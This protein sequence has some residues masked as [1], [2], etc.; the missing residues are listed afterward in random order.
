MKRLILLLLIGLSACEDQ[1]KQTVDG[2]NSFSS[3]ENEDQPIIDRIWLKYGNKEEYILD[4]VYVFSDSDSLVNQTK[5]FTKGR[6]DTLNSHFYDFSFVREND[7]LVKVN[8]NYFSDLY[9]DYKNGIAT[10]HLSIYFTDQLG[11]SIIH[12]TK[13]FD[14]VPMSDVVVSFNLH[15]KEKPILNGFILEQVILK[16]KEYEENTIFRGYTYIDS[17]IS[18]N[19]FD[20]RQYCEK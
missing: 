13:H 18:S 5:I 12:S 17:H 11:D 4:E 16:N 20:I 3:I 8:L 9:I 1:E 15:S 2:I 7:S 10:R 14:D 19:P 6:L